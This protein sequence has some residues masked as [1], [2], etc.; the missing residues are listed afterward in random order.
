MNFFATLFSRRGAAIVGAAMLSACTVVEG[1]GP[2]PGPYPGPR[3]EPGPRFCTREYQPV[4]A[5]RGGERQSFPNACEAD[6][7]GFRVIRDGQCRGDDGGGGMGPGPRPPRPEYPGTR[8]PR[9][10]YPGPG[11]RPPRP[12]PEQTFCTQEYRPVCATR[13]GSTRTFGNSCE[14]R[15]ADYRIV[16]QNGPC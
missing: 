4:C 15:A 3:P 16:D 1:P 8:P 2:G 12:E 9:P 14:A 13:R 10:E 5:R 6:R 11:T 7:A